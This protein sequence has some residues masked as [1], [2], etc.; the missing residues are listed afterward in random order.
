MGRPLGNPPQGGNGAS[1][2]P[3]SGEEIYVLPNAW[4]QSMWWFG[5]QADNLEA[6]LDRLKRG[7]NV[8]ENRVYLTG[9]SDGG[10]GAYF[11]AFRDPTAFASFLPLNGQMLVLANPDSGVDGDIFV[12]NAVNKP[13]FVVNGG[14]DPL[15]PAAGVRPFVEHLRKLGSEVVFHVQEEAGHNTDWWLDERP[16]FEQ[17]VANF[18]GGLS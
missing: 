7:Y 4:P 12:S 5:T 2:I 8:D 6:I 14:R 18:R 16:A 15:Y 10:S 9:I 3:G 11:F 1:R 13:F 17:F